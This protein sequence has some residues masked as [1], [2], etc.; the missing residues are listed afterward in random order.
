M[1]VFNYLKSLHVVAASGTLY[2]EPMC[3]GLLFELCK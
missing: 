1:G 2:Q 3:G